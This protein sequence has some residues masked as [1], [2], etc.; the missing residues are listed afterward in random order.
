VTFNGAGSFD[1]NGT[2]VQWY[3]DFGDGTGT[4]GSTASNTFYGD[5][6]VTQVYAVTLTVWDNQGLARTSVVTIGVLCDGTLSG[7]FCPV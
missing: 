6:Y 3:W 4:F 1:P 2:V 7:F 5:P